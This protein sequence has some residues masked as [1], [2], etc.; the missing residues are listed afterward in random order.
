MK[1]YM[2]IAV[3][4]LFLIGLNAY[5]QEGEATFDALRCGVCHR[6]DTGEAMPSLKTI[7]VAYKGKEYQL[8][9]YLKGDSESIVS[10]QKKGA[11]KAY[12]EKTKILEEDQRKALADFI[13]SH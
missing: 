11:M 13:L 4:G 7:A 9:S 5:A 3:A 8:L 1:Y 2:L 6:P 10:P 12:I